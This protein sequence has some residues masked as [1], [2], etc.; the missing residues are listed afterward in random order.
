MIKKIPQIGVE[1]NMA[2]VFLVIASFGEIFGV[3]YINMF[4]RNKS[5]FS[6][7]MIILSMGLGFLFLSL[8]M[9]DI[10]LG[11][12]YAIWTGLGAAGA[13]LIGI[14]FFRSEEHTSELQSRGHLVCRLLL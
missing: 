8:A 7:F 13:V 10:P 4:V 14:L 1:H 5:L 2:W 12:A 6:L 11:T 9:R 3:M